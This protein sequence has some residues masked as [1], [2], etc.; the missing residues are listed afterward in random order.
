MKNNL[1][2]LDKRFYIVTG[3][4]GLLGRQ[5]CEAIL[6]AQGIPIAVD[7]NQ[8][9]LIE[10]RDELKEIYNMD[11]Q[12]QEVTKVLGIL[13]HTEFYEPEFLTILIG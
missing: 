11:F 13:I 9:R 8:D 2:Y 7:L 12:I 5:H 10:M 4:A 6:S 1:F 3:A